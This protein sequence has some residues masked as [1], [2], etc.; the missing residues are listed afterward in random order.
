MLS[1]RRTTVLS[2]LGA[3]A[4]VA[5]AIATPLSASAATDGQIFA[6][7]WTTGVVGSVDRVSGAFT[8]IGPANAIDITGFDVDPTTG[9]AYAVDYDSTCSLQSVN[10]DTGVI[11]PI[12]LLIGAGDCTA[13]DIDEAGVARVAYDDAVDGFSLA[14]VDL[15]TGALTD[16]AVGTPRLSSLATDPTTGVLYAIDYSD[17]AYSVDPATGNGTPVGTLSS[18]AYAADFDS[19]GVIWGS[20]FDNLISV[21]TTDWAVTTVG[22]IAEAGV[23]RN[24]EALTVF[25][26]RAP[27]A[28]P[29]VVTPAA[30]ALP[31]TGFDGG[32]LASGALALA[33]IGGAL[34]TVR[35]RAAT[36][37]A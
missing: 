6:I 8:A 7:E 28:V 13:F 26:Y 14:E 35:A 18:T 36:L 20:A 11:A 12:A 25:R 30:A 3:V 21:S 29:A 32:L 9:L 37:A 1:R 2:G 24:S 16:V 5:L 23:Q 10:L 22:P 15:A 34:L 31:D 4:A 33:L 27:V 19:S 17:Q